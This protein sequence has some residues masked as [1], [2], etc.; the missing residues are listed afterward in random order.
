[1]NR[2]ELLNPKIPSATWDLSG[3]FVFDQNFW[4]L[5]EIGKHFYDCDIPIKSIHGCFAVMWNAGRI[6]SVNTPTGGG[7]NT[8]GPEEIIKEWGKYPVPIGCYYTFSNPLIKEEH[9]DDPGSNWLLD[10]LAKHNKHKLNGVIVSSEVLSNYIRKKYPELK[11]KASIVKS[12][13]E[14]PKV[15]GRDFKYYDELTERFDI[16]M[17]HP[18][19]GHNKELLKQIADSGKQNKYELILNENCPIGCTYRKPCYIYQA[20]TGVR[21]WNGP[22]HFYDYKEEFGASKPGEDPR[23]GRE[24][25]FNPNP[26]HRCTTRSCNFTQDELIEVYNMGFTQYKLQGRDTRWGDIFYDFSRYALESDYVTP[27]L[28]KLKAT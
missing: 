23:C 21:D 1:M 25:Y 26:E 10:I 5:L 28:L 19:D 13:V 12:S 22:F 3:L 7:S 11:Q 24:N 14:K 9:L 20:Q 4:H 16:V 2:T 6:T 18:D 17:I 8:V 15:F 27:I